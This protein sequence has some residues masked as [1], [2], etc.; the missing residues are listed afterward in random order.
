MVGQPLK[1]ITQKVL[2]TVTTNEETHITILNQVFQSYLTDSPIV[3]N[4]YD[5][6]RM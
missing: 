3:A 2:S 6:S 5:F 1:N 4:T